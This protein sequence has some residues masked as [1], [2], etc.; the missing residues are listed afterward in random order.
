MSIPKLKNKVV[1]HQTFQF[2][3]II[4]FVDSNGIQTH[5]HLVHKR[6]LNHLT[7]LAKWSSVH[8]GTKSYFRYGSCFK[9]G[10]L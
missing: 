3:E 2:S 9:Q 7:S 1:V 10:V 6:T 8:L 4:L 5:N